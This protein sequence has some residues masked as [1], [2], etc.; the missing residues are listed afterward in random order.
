MKVSQIEIFLAISESGSIAEAARRIGKSRTTL[1]SALTALEDEL[2]V[3][4]LTRTGNQVS[5]TNIGEV[6]KNDCERLAMIANDITGRC[7]QHLQGVEASLRIARDDALPEAYWRQLIHEMSRQ[8]PSISVSVYMAPPPE[9]NDMVEQGVVD[10]AYCLLPQSQQLTSSHQVKLGEIRMMTVASKGHPLTTLSQ[11]VKADLSRYTEFALATIDETGLHAVTPVSGNY[12]ALPFYE[13]L[14]NAVLDG[15][16][17][18]SVPSVLIN[19][20]LRD[21]SV[22]VLKYDQAMTSQAYGMIQTRYSQLGRLS[23]WLAQQIAAYL[24]ES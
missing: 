6:I 2:G 10:I 24:S 13:H 14:R 22:K 1:S 5:L 8:F 9:L 23:Q 11:V 7:H 20:Y 21:G 16:G 15:T 12:I 4:L 18:A 19:P 17:F 3:E